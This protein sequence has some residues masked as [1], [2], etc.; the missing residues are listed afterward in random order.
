MSQATQK[1]TNYIDPKSIMRIKSLE[2]RAKAI[3]EGFLS[4]LHRSPYHGFSVEFTE[5][6]Q[7]TAGD[8]LRYLDWKLFARSDRYYIKCFEDETNLRCQLLV[9]LSRSMNYGTLGFTKA[10]YAK[11]AAATL[12]YFLSLQRDAVGV[13]TFD[14]QIGEYL[15]PRFRPGHIHRLMMC[16][17]RATG[18][19]STDIE[20][21]IENV[22][23]T[24]SKRGVIVLF[25]DML[26]PLGTLDKTLGYLRSCGHEVVIFRTLDPREVDFDF[27]DPAMFQDIETQKEVYID[28]ETARADYL[29]KFGEHRESLK[30]I[31][32]GLGV[33]LLELTCDQSLELV[34]LD[35]LNSRQLADRGAAR[36][37]NANGGMR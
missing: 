11:T 16:L 33:E 7:Y 8:D 14:E 19:T 13:T 27:S 18:G 23:S 29:Q 10:E 31:C 25:S 30:E 9:D 20:S 21:A 35:Y 28:P 32:D 17:E 4:G 15:P 34:L 36:T 2:L 5:Y 24:V 12:A 1:T 3:V 6:R 26:S 37:R 22:I